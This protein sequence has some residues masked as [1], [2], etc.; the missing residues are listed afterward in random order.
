MQQNGNKGEIYLNVSPDQVHDSPSTET[1]FLHRVVLHW[2]PQLEV[3]LDEPGQRGG[4]RGD[5]QLLLGR[6]RSRRLRHFTVVIPET[7]T[8]QVLHLSTIQRACNKTG[9]KK[10][11]STGEK[12]VG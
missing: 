11:S 5:G 4:W 12:E 10:L 1:G 3:A 9:L 7:G 8:V 2:F 6:Q